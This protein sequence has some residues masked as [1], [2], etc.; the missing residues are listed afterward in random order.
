MTSCTTSGPDSRGVEI[1][2]VAVPD[3]RKPGGLAVI[4]AMPASFRGEEGDTP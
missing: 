2:L 4:H 1:E 3:D